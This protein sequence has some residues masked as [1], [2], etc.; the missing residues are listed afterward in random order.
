MIRQET[1]AKIWHAYREMEVGLKML[2]DLAAAQDEGGHSKHAR[3]LPDAFGRRRTL[4]LGV[5]AGSDG[6]R[7]LDVGPDLADAMIRAH[8]AAQESLLDGLMVLARKE[9][10]GKEGGAE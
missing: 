10:D 2:E 1:A 9:L 3:Q 4:Q 8:I 5:P 7:L 6:H